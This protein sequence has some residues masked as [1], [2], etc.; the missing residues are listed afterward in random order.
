MQDML[1]RVISTVLI[2]LGPTVTNSS[3]LPIECRMTVNSLVLHSSFGSCDH[4]PYRSYWIRRIVV[5]QI[6][7]LDS[8]TQYAVLIRRFDTSYPTGGYGVS[9]LKGLVLPAQVKADD[10]KIRSYLHGYGFGISDHDAVRVCLLLV[11]TI[12]FMGRETRTL[13]VVPR[14]NE[15]DS[16]KDKYILEIFPNNKYWW[17]KDPDVIPHG[18]SCFQYFT[19]RHESFQTDSVGEVLV[20]DV[21]QEQN[22]ICLIGD[23][24]DE[25][26]QFD[27]NIHSDDHLPN[28]NST[29]QDMDKESNIHSHDPVEH[30]NSPNICKEHVLAEFD[31]IKATFD[32]IDK[33][34]GEVSTY[35]LEK[36]L[37]IVKDRIAVLEKCF[38]LRYHDTFEDSVKQLYYKQHDFHCSKSDSA[39]SDVFHQKVASEKR[40]WPG[41]ASGFIYAESQDKYFVSQLLQLV[42]NEKSGPVFDCTQ[43]EVDTPIDWSLPI[44]NEPFSQSHICGSVGFNDMLDPKCKDHQLNDNVLKG[45]VKP[46]D[47]MCGEVNKS[48]DKLDETLAVGVMVDCA[49]LQSSP[50]LDAMDY[51]ESQPTDEGSIGFDDMLDP[52]SK[53]HL[54]NDTALKVSVGFDDMMDPGCKDQPLNDN[55][56]KG[57]VKL[58][59]TMSGED[60]ISD[61]KLD[62]MVVGGVKLLIVPCIKQ[63]HLQMLCNIK[64]LT[65]SIMLRVTRKAKFGLPPYT[66]LP[67]TTPILK[68]RQSKRLKKNA[69][70]MDNF[71]DDCQI[72]PLKYWLEDL[73][74]PPNSYN[75]KVTLPTYFDNIYHLPRKTTHIFSWNKTSHSVD[76]DFWLTLLGCSNRGWLSDKPDD[77]WAIVGPY[78]CALVMRGEVPF[79]LANGVKYHVPWIEVDR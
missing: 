35:C 41:E 2:L 68:K 37:D 71:D 65:Q 44:L 67:S 43:L 38:K 7:R 17:K 14:K 54:L 16:K 51:Q 30:Q 1:P 49:T 28:L 52:S 10:M 57:L 78:F 32:I 69:I 26:S 19:N 75:K 3:S 8:K 59:D 25:T 47:M 46:V 60:N 53:D 76:R 29:F 40:D 73:S 55:V 62:E 61:Y 58:V 42:S 22:L 39:V 34:K 27:L 77:D 12:V 13:N 56:P 4:L 48:N 64:N 70:P 20:H 63:V 66:P 79:W 15:K 9:V 45:L 5:K 50:P 24:A 72:I 11:A 74:R 6:R 23:T 18:I 36:E 21:E 31:A 33:R